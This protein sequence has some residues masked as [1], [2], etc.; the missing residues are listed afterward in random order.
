M[1][2]T[3]LETINS[4]VWGVPTLLLF[5]G[6]GFWF[7]VRLRWLQL[8]KLP[9]A[10]RAIRADLKRS[11]SGPDGQNL[12]TSAAL[13]A[14]LGAVMGPGNLIGVSSA[15]LIGG[16]GA[17]FWMWVS[18]LLGMA[19]RYVESAL[20]VR[21]RKTYNGKN[22]GGPM[23]VM[24]SFGLRRSAVLFS[25]AGVFVSLTMANALPAGAL[26]S[27]LSEQYGIPTH[28]T[29]VVLCIF[30]CITIF[31]GGKRISKV[32]AVLVPVV[33]IFFA[34][35]SLLV[36]VSHPSELAAAVS[37]VFRGAFSLRS[38]LG[39]LLGTTVRYGLARGIYSNEA[40]MGTEPIMAA[41]TGESDPHRQGLISMTGPFL[42]TVV[43]CSF[44][45][46]VVLMAGDIPGA[47]AASLASL[48]FAKFLPGCGGFIV[49][50]TMTLLVLAT[51]ASWAFYGERC[52]AYVCR[53][54]IAK[55]L[56]RVAY[57]LM[58]LV[59]AGASLG[60]IFTLT[61]I[62]TALMA[63]PNLFVCIRYASEVCRLEKETS[64]MSF[65]V[66]SAGKIAYNIH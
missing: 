34:G 7:S 48:A 22:I 16:A 52:I 46:V 20:S 33:C 27:S 54:N 19:V 40:G 55:V 56:Y 4:V 58:P 10:F 44:T 60:I 28:L 42:D 24:R 21:Y 51:L 3:I 30:T 18:A 6:S 2:K 17:V 14:S 29:G 5:V 66:D 23:Y 45:A 57:A 12:S 39:G 38:G 61:D 53:K 59:C 31:G 64:H 41:A 9:E 37:A 26:G 50:A 36:V 63:L 8:R 35:A 47:T 32:S 13:L 62:A 43:F 65:G 49:D 11:G 1:L 25:V 15:I